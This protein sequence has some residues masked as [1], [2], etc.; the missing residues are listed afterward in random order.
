MVLRSLERAEETSMG[1]TKAEEES[2][3]KEKSQEAQARKKGEACQ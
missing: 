2:S 1:P 3:R